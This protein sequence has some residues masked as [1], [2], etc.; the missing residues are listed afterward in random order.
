MECSF[1][2]RAKARA[3][4]RAREWSSWIDILFRIQANG[5]QIC[6]NACSN[7]TCPVSVSATNLLISFRDLWYLCSVI[8]FVIYIAYICRFV[9]CDEGLSCAFGTKYCNYKRLSSYNLGSLLHVFEIW[10][11]FFRC[12]VWLVSDTMGFVGIHTYIHIC[13]QWALCLKQ[14]LGL[15]KNNSALSLHQ[16]WPYVVYISIYIYSYGDLPELIERL[17]F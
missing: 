6:E 12:C 10:I 7:I 1:R 17:S 2:E 5:Q 3:R 9:V 15:G 13:I 14:H 16:P 4:T 11:R 8:S